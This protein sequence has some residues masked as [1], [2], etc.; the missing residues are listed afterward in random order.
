MKNK[1]YI[2]LYYFPDKKEHSKSLRYFSNHRSKS[3][4]NIED[5]KN[6]FQER[7]GEPFGANGER[8]LGAVLYKR[9]KRG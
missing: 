6:S 8:F 3:K 4:A 7:F 1:E 2:A 5:F 9:I